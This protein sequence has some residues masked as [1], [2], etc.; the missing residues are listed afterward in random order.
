MLIDDGPD[1]DID[2]SLFNEAWQR[3]DPGGTVFRG[4]LMW[5]DACLLLAALGTAPRPY[6]VTPDWWDDDDE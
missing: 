5:D 3:I 4:G 6:L 2:M 1:G